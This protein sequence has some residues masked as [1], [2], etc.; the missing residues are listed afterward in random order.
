MWIKSVKSF[1]HAKNSNP[2]LAFGDLPWIPLDMAKSLAAIT[3]FLREAYGTEAAYI[4]LYGS[5][6]RGDAT[7][8]SDVDIAVFLNHEVPW[9][10]SIHGL[11]DPA[12]ACKDRSRWH[13]I[14]KRANKKR[15][16]SRVYSIN[17]V[18]QGMLYY[19][20]AH[21]PIHLQNWAHALMNSYPLGG[22][23]PDL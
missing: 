11:G 3:S 7:P 22:A 12:A 5:W 16:D 9:F 20:L 15:L 8:D 21:G 17:V 4:G 2:D 13:A 19:Y 1:K 14:E 6:Q 10:D 23:A 18:T